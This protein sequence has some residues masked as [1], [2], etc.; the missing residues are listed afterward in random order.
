MKNSILFSF[1]EFCFKCYISYYLLRWSASSSTW[2]LSHSFV[3]G[4]DVTWPLGPFHIQSM[5]FEVASVLSLIKEIIELNRY[6]VR[7]FLYNYSLLHSG[8]H[9]PHSVLS[10]PLWPSL[11]RLVS[12]I[13]R[14]RTPSESSQLL[15]G[16]TSRISVEQ[17]KITK[18]V[19]R[20]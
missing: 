9:V 3:E 8:K 7:L 16:H 19:S 5:A 1:W 20:L 11:L 12:H 15:L 10:S 14:R 4:F 18:N 17:K 13:E 2:C 6:Q